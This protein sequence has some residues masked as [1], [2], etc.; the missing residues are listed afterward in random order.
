MRTPFVFT[1]IATISGIVLAIDGIRCTDMVCC[2]LNETAL[3]KCHAHSKRCPG[4]VG[5]NFLR[6]KAAVG[7]DE[8][9]YCPPGECRVGTTCVCPS[10]FVKN[11]T[12]QAHCVISYTESWPDS[13]GHVNRNC[14]VVDPIDERRRTWFKALARRRKKDSPGIILGALVAVIAGGFYF[15]VRWRR[16]SR[17]NEPLVNQ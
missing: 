7:K 10:D 16:E 17:I 15:I 8:C 13:V 4:F 9:A 14:T 2:E 1:L 5:T 12:L 3:H 11:T 6:G